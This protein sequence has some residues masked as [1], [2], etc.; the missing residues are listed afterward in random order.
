MTTTLEI[1]MIS[2]NGYKSRHSQPECGYAL[3]PSQWTEYSIHT[4]DPDNLELTFEFFEVIQFNTIRQTLLSPCVSLSWSQSAI[5]ISL[6]VSGL[7]KYN[8]N[9]KRTCI[10]RWIHIKHNR[11]WEMSI[12]GEYKSV[13]RLL[14][15]PYSLVKCRPQNVS[16]PQRISQAN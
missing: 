6:P 1:S 3:E 16:L 10:A 2:A 13:L 5:H 12:K 7:N 11:S 9:K 8:R 4:M 14:H 15:N